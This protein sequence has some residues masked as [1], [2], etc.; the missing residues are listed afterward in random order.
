MQRR[1]GWFV[2]ALAIVMSVSFNASAFAQGGAG[3]VAGS[4]SGVVIDKDGGV[5]PGATVEIKNNATSEKTMLVTNSAGVFTQPALSAG[6]YTVTVSLSGFKTFVVNDVRVLSSQVTSVPKITLQVGQV[7]EIVNVKAASEL[8]HTQQTKISNTITAE[9]ITNLPVVSR[10]ALNFV[11]FLPNV[12]TAG[13][14]RASTIAGLPSNAINISIDGV[15]TNNLLQSG[16]G[17][18]SMVVPRLDAVEE[19]SLSMAGESADASA[20]G[21]AQIKFVTRSGTNKFQGTGYFYGR[22]PRL[23]TNYYFNEIAFDNAAQAIRPLPKN[24]VRVYQYGGSEGGPIVIPNLFD[25]RGKAF[26]FHNFEVF[27][28]PNQLN[29]TRTVL[30]ESMRSGVLTYST[31][32]SGVT[33]VRTIDLF[34]QM[35]LFANSLAGSNPALAARI[36]AANTPDPTLTALLAKIR[37]STTKQGVINSN[38]GTSAS[39]RSTESYIWQPTGL[40][41]QLSP[42]TK[43]DVNLNSKNRLSGSYWAQRFYAKPDL[44]NNNEQ[45]FPGFLNAGDQYSWRTTGSASLRTTVGQGMVNT[46]QGGWQT[47]PNHF[48]DNIKNGNQFED[49]TPPGAFMPISLT[50]P[51][52]TAATT[53]RNLAPRNTPNWNINDDFSWLRGS[54]SLTFGGSFSQIINTQNTEDVAQNV[55]LGFAN[56]SE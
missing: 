46:L 48:N 5:I 26:F 6:T 51:T 9:Q 38:T 4:L 7:T 21:A 44:L 3:A 13:T 31:T 19:V 39:A 49:Q 29:R 27:R 55:S 37:E 35:A 34:G 30:T 40:L 10:N 25:G 56:R 41:R 16:D 22:D 23:N 2:A 50:V 11:V 8:I 52:I 18:F 54:H 12:Q 42:T 53:T 20:Q 15:T 1:M 17:F 24:D 32:A 36:L 14:A 47:S 33:T 45:Q 43:V 28:Q